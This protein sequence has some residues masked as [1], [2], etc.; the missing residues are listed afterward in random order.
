VVTT[1]RGGRELS[2][3]EIARIHE[4]YADGRHRP[5]FGVCIDNCQQTPE[6]TARQILPKLFLRG[7]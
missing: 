1:N 2:A 6:E 3:R 4:Q 5:P 7:R